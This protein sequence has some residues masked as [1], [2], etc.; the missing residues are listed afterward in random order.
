VRAV[1]YRILN[2]GDRF[3]VDHYLD[4]F[5]R[6]GSSDRFSFVYHS[7]VGGL[8]LPAM[9]GLHLW[10]ADRLADVVIDA[11]LFNWLMERISVGL[12]KIQSR[13]SLNRLG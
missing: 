8:S 2:Q 10:T 11:G 7:A 12:S 9:P 3:E 5:R 1:P 4:R 6:D 13:Y